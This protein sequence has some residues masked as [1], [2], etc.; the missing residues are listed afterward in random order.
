VVDALS[1]PLDGPNHCKRAAI[2]EGYKMD[3]EM[4]VWNWIK[5]K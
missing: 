3:L 5:A 2:H 4:E 1:Y